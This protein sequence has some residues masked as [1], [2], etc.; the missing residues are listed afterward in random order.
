M[1]TWRAMIP[2]ENMRTLLN[3]FLLFFFVTANAQDRSIEYSVKAT[4][5]YKLI[6]FVDWPP[7]SFAAPDSPLQ[8]CVAGKDP[9]GSLIDQAV[10][11]VVIGQR[12]IEIKRPTST[13]TRPMCH[14]LF[15]GGNSRT[16]KSWLSVTKD[17]PILTV[18]ELD[19]G[20]DPVGIINFVRMNERVRFAVDNA[21]A[22]KSQLRLSTKLLAL[23]TT[24]VGAPP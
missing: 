8:L 2:G 5:L 21:A 13:A 4:Y 11:N 15:I 19:A 17:Y 24:V 10:E 16:V 7:E 3:C 9:F 14:V 23:A 18:T 1:M 12:H 20:D 22:T 6:P